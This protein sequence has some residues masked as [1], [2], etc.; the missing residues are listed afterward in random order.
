MPREKA[1][2]KKAEKLRRSEGKNRC[3]VRDCGGLILV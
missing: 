2:N 3:V 1:E